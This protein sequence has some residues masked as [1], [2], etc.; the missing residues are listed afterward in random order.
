MQIFTET[1]RMVFGPDINTRIDETGKAMSYRPMT[2]TGRRLLGLFYWDIQEV[3]AIPMTFVFAPMSEVETAMCSDLWDLREMMPSKFKRAP[4][5][6]GYL[7]GVNQVVNA[8][9]CRIETLGVLGDVNECPRRYL[10]HL[11][12][13]IAYKLKNEREQTV[14]QLREQIKT[15]IEIY[16]IKGTYNVLNYAF[17]LIGLQA[18]VWDLWTKD[19]RIFERRAPHF[20]SGI[21][22]GFTPDDG[23]KLDDGWHADHLTFADPTA[24]GVGDPGGNFDGGGGFKSPH[25]DIVIQLNKLFYWQGI[26]EKLFVGSMW[27]AIEEILE[28]FTPINTVPHMFLG[29]YLK[30][31]EDY[32]VYS[33]PLLDST[34]PKT[35]IRTTIC[36]PWEMQTIYMDQATPPAGTAANDI[37]MDQGGVDVLLGTGDGGETHFSKTITPAGR[38]RRSK[39]HLFLDDVEVASDDGAGHWVSPGGYVTGGSINYATGSISATFASAP[40]AGVA[41]NFHSAVLEL[42]MDQ[43]EASKLAF[44]TVFQI[45]TGSKG[46]APDHGDLV[47]QTPVHTGAISKVAV[48]NEKISFT[49]QIPRGVVINGCSELGLFHSGTGQMMVMSTF[50]DFDKPAGM[51]VDIT[52]EVF[53]NV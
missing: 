40:G 28:E 30:C 50:P 27:A 5:M 16:K 52:V 20:H 36:D 12:A 6:M 45:G 2:A 41:V 8:I 42:F 22:G 17:F 7:A 34:D 43:S 46:I 3:M 29:L 53:R 32:Q 49:M 15:A 44:I 10:G 13:L 31:L 38:V 25:F 24:A 39:V 37:Y 21:P 9:S 11:S 33:I 48:T 4:V 47:L 51:A 1:G 19:Y 35:M 14:A 26:Y 18:Q 23:L